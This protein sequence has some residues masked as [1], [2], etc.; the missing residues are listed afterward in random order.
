VGRFLGKSNSDSKGDT[1]SSPGEDAKGSDFA[2]KDLYKKGV[3][4]MASEK[5]EEAIRSFDLAL[6]IDPAYVDA[7]IKKGYCHFHLDD[8]AQAVASYDKALQ[9][10]V[11][12]AE[13]WNM[14]GLAYYKMKNSEKA[15]E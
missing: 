4:Q 13:A 7:W 2:K 12:N 9:I 15:I 3:N 5:L 10:D 6:R 8:Y 1:D 14:K 11:N